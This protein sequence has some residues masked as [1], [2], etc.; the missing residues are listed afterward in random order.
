MKLKFLWCFLLMGLLAAPLYAQQIDTTKLNHYLDYITK[1][2]GYI[3]NISIYKNGKEVYNRYFGQ[4]HLL[5]ADF[6]KNTNYRIASISKVFTACLIWQLIERHQL[7]LTDK[8]SDFFPKM[9]N[10]DKITIKNLL[11]HSSGLKD[12]GIKKGAYYWLLKPV[13]KEAILA[14]IRK[15]GV[16]FQPGEGISYSNSGYY[17]LGQIVEMT[18]HDS[19]RHILNQQ[20]IQPLHLKNTGLAQAHP[21][22]TFPSYKYNYTK[23]RWRT[24][25]EDYFKNAIGPGGMVSTPKALNEFILKLFHYKLLS[26][27]TID[28]MKPIMGKESYGRGL[29]LIPFY[30]H[31]SYGHAGDIHGTHSLVAY[32]PDENLAIAFALN[33]ARKNRNSFGVA[34]LNII[35][36]LDFDYP[37]FYNKPLPLAK[38]HKYTGTYA[39]PEVPQKLTF[40]VKNG[41]LKVKNPAL[42]IPYI[43]LTPLTAHEFAIKSFAIKVK[44]YPEENFLILKQ[45]GKEFKMK[46]ES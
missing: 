37:T 29:M 39:T 30:Q 46:K 23:G 3:G 24:V 13:E 11:E 34:I 5:E 19:Y 35:Y 14:E 2:N 12:Y 25:K 9:P 21:T 8:L 6:D 1:E 43:R 28:K 36:G 15:Q 32:Y 33:G 16:S 27:Q 38:L 10:A 40:K 45:G 22:N 44:F 18:Y 31:I 42:G 41:V 4:S 17:L 20:I 7:N 26:K